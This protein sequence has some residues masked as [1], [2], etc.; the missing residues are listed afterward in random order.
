MITI[1][2]VQEARERIKPHIRETQLLYARKISEIA[3]GEIYLKLENLQKS[4]SFK[5]RGATNKIMQLPKEATKNGVIASSAGNHAQGVAHSATSLGIKSTIV[6]PAGAPIA[7]VEATK[8]FGAEV[9]LHGAIYDDAYEKACE[10]QKEHGY[11]FV[12]PFNDEDV[13]AGQGTIA[14]EIFEQLEKIDQ[15][16]C[17]IGGGGII[18]GIAVVAKTLNPKCK[19]IGVQASNCAGMQ[20]AIKKGKIE[21][22][23]GKPSL[24]DGI[25]VAKPGDV[26]YEYVKKYVDEIVTVTEDEIA[27]TILYLLEK[28]NII[29]E[30]AGTVS[31]AAVLKGKI[32]T[33]DKNTVC[34][35]SGGNI[36]ITLVER[37]INNGLIATGRR[38]EIKLSVANKQGALINVL[39]N[40]A[41]LGANIVNVRNSITR[42]G[43]GATEH[44]LTIVVDTRD[45]DHQ[46]ELI[47]SLEDEG[48]TVTS[49]IGH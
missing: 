26:T 49:N 38:M 23:D 45:R 5:L 17:P 39:D 7:K 13:I 24:A 36:D 30:G 16:V 46:L 43:L 22:I 20:N 28:C 18:A 41:E 44:G 15:I 35:V 34:I 25:A 9:V 12:H 4:G 10:L 29:A 31:T 48:Y 40:I 32:N 47:K 8:N 14:L 33:K 37:I 3:G 42:P 27:E 19:I 2:E 11:T 6:M 21:K 1:K